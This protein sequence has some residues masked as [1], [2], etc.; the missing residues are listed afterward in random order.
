[1]SQAFMVGPQDFSSGGKFVLASSEWNAALTYATRVVELSTTAMPLSDG[2]AQSDALRAEVAAFRDRT[3]PSV[4]Q[5]ASQVSQF[6]MLA[7]TYLPVLDQV[8]KELGASPSQSVQDR[9]DALVA[10][11]QNGVTPAIAAATAASGAV[12]RFVAL[13]QSERARLDKLVQADAKAQAPAASA[14]GSPFDLA[15]A[16]LPASMQQ[17]VFAWAR[18]QSVFQEMQ[19]WVDE[20]VKMGAPFQVDLSLEQAL[21]EWNDVAQQAESFSVNAYTEG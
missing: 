20:Q 8:L 17:L 18:L 5:L 19:A 1:M 4:V 3:Y 21:Q 7:P 15:F 9:F 13:A 2:P 12:T 10:E 16:D 14:G 6:A 11:I